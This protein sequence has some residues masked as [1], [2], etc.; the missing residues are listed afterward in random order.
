MAALY[1]PVYAVS[2]GSRDGAWNMAFD[3]QL[4]ALFKKGGFQKKFGNKSMLWR[5]YTWESPALSLGY[6]QQLQEID[7]MSCRARNI[8]IVRRPTGGRAVL[9]ADEFTYALFAETSR[10]NAEIYAMAHEVIRDA[11]SSLG[12]KAEFSRTTPD[13]RQRYNSAESVSCFT[14]SARNEIHV[15]GRKLVGSAQRRSDRA[16]LQHGSLL[17]S[18]KHK[19]I[20]KLLS[21]RDEK[22]LSRIMDDLDCKTVSLRE[23]TGHMP[24]FKTI[25]N[26]MIASISKTIGT[27]VRV[28]DENEI[29]SLF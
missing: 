13:M 19:L 17:L 1:S 23:L 27:E 3:T 5:F 7:E 26:A 28:L 11:L 22:T 15:D 8:A 25:S 9:H 14:A 20:G 24:D 16:V 12:V 10:S 29:T 21:C 6:G 4:L 18:E 2:T